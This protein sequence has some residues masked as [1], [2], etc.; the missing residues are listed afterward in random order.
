MGIHNIDVNKCNINRETPLMVAS[1]GGYTRIV[2]KLLAHY[3]M[4]AN[5]ATFE[6]KTAVRYGIDGSGW[7]FNTMKF[8]PSLFQSPF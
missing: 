2:K 7:Q 5:F 3:K 6:G 8:D 1:A 4:D